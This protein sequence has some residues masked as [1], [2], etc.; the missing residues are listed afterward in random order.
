MININQQEF[1]TLRDAVSTFGS[2]A[3]L[4]QLQEECGELIA[5]INHFMRYKVDAS[6][7]F[8]S[9]FVDVYIVMSQIFIAMKCPNT[10][11]NR[12]KFKMS[13]LEQRI[14]EVKSHE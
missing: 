4:R 13:K 11:Q 8:L 10:F 9:E 3:Q 2:E 6:E 7:E 1:E 14:K 12:F 5:A